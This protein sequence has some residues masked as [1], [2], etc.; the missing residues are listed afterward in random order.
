MRAEAD[1][2]FAND[3]PGYVPPKSAVDNMEYTLGTLKEALRKYSV[4]PVVTRRCAKDDDMAGYK[5]PK[6]AW[7]F[8]SIQVGIFIKMLLVLY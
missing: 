3:K 2:V 8:V 6:G 7:V 1:V 4:V 5:I